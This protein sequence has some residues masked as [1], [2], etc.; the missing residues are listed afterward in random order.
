VKVL[1]DTSVIVA[2]MVKD[3]PR[4]AESLPWL[5][6]VQAEEIEGYIAIHTLAEVYAVITRLSCTPAISPE[7]APWLIIE[8]LNGFHTVVLTAEDYQGTIA[9]MMSVNLSGENIY[10]GLIAVAAIKAGVDVLLTL[11]PD[12]FMKMGEDVA[13][14][15]KAPG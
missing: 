11:N 6:R 13:P 9:R 10:D 1:F 2:A 5:Q 4:H 3:H 7:L 14:L 12:D 15:V 8:N